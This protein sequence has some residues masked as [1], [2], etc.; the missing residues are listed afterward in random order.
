MNDAQVVMNAAEAAALTRR[1][2][3]PDIPEVIGRS[4]E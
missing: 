2:I 3:G 1:E 4:P